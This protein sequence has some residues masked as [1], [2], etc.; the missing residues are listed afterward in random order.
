MSKLLDET[1]ATKMQEYERMTLKEVKQEKEKELRL[2]IKN[3]I[4]LN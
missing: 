1:L 2:N 3:R 4:K